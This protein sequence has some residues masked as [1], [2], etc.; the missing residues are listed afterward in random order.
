MAYSSSIT[1]SLMFKVVQ[2]LFVHRSLILMDLV[3][4]ALT[5]METTHSHISIYHLFAKCINCFGEYWIASTNIGET[6]G[7][8]I[9]NSVSCIC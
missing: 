6:M 1:M 5:N 9:V 8:F 7:T 4:N 3:H 2:Q